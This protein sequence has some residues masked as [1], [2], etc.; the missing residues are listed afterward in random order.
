[1][2]IATLIAF[3]RNDV[4]IF[5]L[6]RRMRQRYRL[7]HEYCRCALWLGNWNQWAIE[8]SIFCHSELAQASEESRIMRI[9][10]CFGFAST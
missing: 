1:M 8:D 7:R 6:Q 5:Y 4:G 10:R 9:M 3:A 2:L